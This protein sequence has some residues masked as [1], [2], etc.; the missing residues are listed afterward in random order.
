MASMG[1]HSET[2]LVT[3]DYPLEPNDA[4]RALI[5]VRP[6]LLEFV[7]EIAARDPIFLLAHDREA[8][9][10]ASALVAKAEGWSAQ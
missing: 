7:K 8:V 9:A 3:K 6:E 1:G 2:I 5:A 10:K 4:N